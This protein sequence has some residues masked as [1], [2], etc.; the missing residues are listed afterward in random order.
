V[1]VSERFSMEVCD[2]AGMD[3]QPATEDAKFPPR[4]TDILC[5]RR[6]LLRC[7]VWRQWD[8]IFSFLFFSVLIDLLAF[9]CQCG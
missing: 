7:G 8:Y 6:F 2:Q 3:F 9:I 4:S 1:Q 5:G